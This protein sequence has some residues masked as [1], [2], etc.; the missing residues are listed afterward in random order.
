MALHVRARHTGGVLSTPHCP[1]RAGRSRC[2]RPLLL[3]CGPALYWLCTAR[4]N[5]GGAC[6]V[7]S[8]VSLLW[9]YRS[10]LSGHT[11]S[12]RNGCNTALLRRLGVRR[13]GCNTA[14]LT[15]YFTLRLWVDLRSTSTVPRSQ[16]SSCRCTQQVI[17]SSFRRGQGSSRAGL[18]N[19]VSHM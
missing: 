3:L 15:S 8:I 11:A 1:S 5:R 4:M 13:N 19:V 12:G 10:V 6:V 18:V 16:H 17:S 14:L 2:L 9:F 7:G